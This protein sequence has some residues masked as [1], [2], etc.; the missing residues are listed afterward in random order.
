MEHAPSKSLCEIRKADC[1]SLSRNAHAIQVRSCDP[2]FHT[3][4]SQRRDNDFCI[5]YDYLY[6]YRLLALQC[7]NMLWTDSYMLLIRYCSCD[8]E[9]TRNLLQDP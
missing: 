7:T 5:I 2:L 1:R 9:A 6:E 4:M 3:S 8:N